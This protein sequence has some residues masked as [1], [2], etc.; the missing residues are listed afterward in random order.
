M[1]SV[2]LSNRDDSINFEVGEPMIV[3]SC[4]A[5]WY[6]RLWRWLTRYSRRH[7]PATLTVTSVDRRDGVITASA[8]VTG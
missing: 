8:L 5:P 6:V 2:T 1:N 3:T 4:T 7:P